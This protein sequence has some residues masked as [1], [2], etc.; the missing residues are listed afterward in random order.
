MSNSPILE[1]KDVTVTYPNLNRAV[2]GVSFSAERNT[3]TAIIGEEKAGRTSL[4][5]AIN[6]LHEL[7]PNI[8]V[9]GS[10]LFNGTNIRKMNTIQVR[11]KIGMIFDTPNPFPNLSIG[12]NILFPFKINKIYLSKTEKE[13][14]IEYY[15]TEV[16]LWNEVKNQLNE[17]PHILS[18]D[19]QQRLCIARSIAIEPEVVLMDEPTLVLNSAGTEKV[20]NM[21][22][23]M[24]DKSTFILVTHNLSQAAR[25]SNYTLFMENGKIVE[26]G[27]T[28][29][30][31]WNPKDK[32][33]E[34]FIN[35]HNQ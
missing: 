27:I 9:S 31:F 21:I 17:K 19:Q 11:R 30:L 4:L 22:Y 35:A 23:R 12:E 25:L 33:T 13:A 3:V 20:E 32:R 14:K 5:R 8:E 18:V 28:S 29:E 2:D 15:L 24:K 26:Y 10:I 1:L 6:R 16:D 7:Y 34:L